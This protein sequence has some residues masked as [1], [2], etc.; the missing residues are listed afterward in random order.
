MP[1][2]SVNVNRGVFCAGRLCDQI[3]GPNSGRTDRSLFWN[4]ADIRPVARVAG[5][6]P[7]APLWVL[8]QPQAQGRALVLPV[9]LALPVLPALAVR[10]CRPLAAQVAPAFLA[11]LEDRQAVAWFAQSRQSR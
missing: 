10:G 1:R 7:S 2:V 8:G 4:S 6:T 9:L 11:V 3:R 5:S